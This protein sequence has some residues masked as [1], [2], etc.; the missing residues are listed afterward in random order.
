MEKDRSPSLDRLVSG[1]A[2]FGIS[3]AAGQ[4]AAF[5]S[6]LSLL[7]RW[8]AK[9]NLTTRLADE[10][11]VVYHFLDSL[12]G[13]H[14]LRHSPAAQV[15]D[16]GAGAGFP[17][18]PLKIALPG[19]RI[20]LVESSRKKISFCREV[21]RS[22]RLQGATAVWGRAEELGELPEHRGKYAWVVSRAMSQAAAVL[23]LAQPFLGPGG[24]VLLYKSEMPEEEKTDLDRLC[25]ELGSSWESRPVIVPYLQAART[26]VVI[27]M[28]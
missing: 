12:S 9:I 26:H 15:I 21:I 7:Q 1:A 17:S 2:E 10:E 5:S 11:V 20:A 24:S 14:W 19:L 18:L 27:R 23:R 16:L 8:G 3:L 6:Y 22:N 4:L 28:K 25:V 13:E